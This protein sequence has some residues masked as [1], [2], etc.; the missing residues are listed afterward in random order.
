MDSFKLQILTPVKESFSGDVQSIIFDIISGR[1]Q[2]LARHADLASGVVPSVVK[3][4]GENSTRY[5]AVSEG[6][7]EF[8][9]NSALLLVD[10]SEWAEEIDLD[11]AKEALERANERMDN[12]D[13]DKIDKDRA[14]R[15][16]I[17]ARARLKAA[18]MKDIKHEEGTV[19]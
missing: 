17:R 10:S 14:K 11:R 18:E 9:D 7:F 5:A 12:K 1:I 8:H 2:I 16:L 19:K 6:F 3:I 13:D 4:E 15:A